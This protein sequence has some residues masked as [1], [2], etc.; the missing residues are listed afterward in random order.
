MPA[1]LT[2]AG[3]YLSRMARHKNKVYVDIWGFCS[4]PPVLSN[5]VVMAEAASTLKDFQA[6]SVLD[7]NERGLV[8]NI[9]TRRSYT[10]E[11]A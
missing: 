4:L 11:P 3:M 2:A 10:A 8:C 1:S 7:L 5:A 6:G 9:I